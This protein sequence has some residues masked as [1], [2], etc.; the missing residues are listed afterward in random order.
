MEFKKSRVIYTIFFGFQLLAFSFLL[1]GCGDEFFDP[2]Q[3]GR[4]RP[5]PSV[6]VIL[7]SLGVAEEAKPVWEGAEEP[8]PVDVVAYE[9]DYVFSSGDVVRVSIF[10]L[11]QEGVTYTN[12]YIITETGKLSIPEVGIVESAG[13]TESQLEDEIKQIVSPSILRE[14]SVTVLLMSSQK[15]SFSI[16]GQAVPKPNRYMIPRYNFRLMDALATAGGISQF[17][18]S[19]VYIS[20]PI[21]G[22]EV[23]NDVGEIIES[24]VTEPEENTDLFIGPDG[25]MLDVITPQAGQKWLPASDQLVVAAAEF[26]CS[27]EL[28]G[29]AAELVCED[30]FTGTA[31]PEGIGL[32]EFNLI[33]EQ[34]QADTSVEQ[35][36]KN[37]VDSIDVQ[38]VPNEPQMKCELAIEP[39]PKPQQENGSIEWVFEDGKWIPVQT[40]QLDAPQ[41]PSGLDTSE[42]IGKLAE[43]VPDDFDW[44]QVGT[45]GDQTRVIEIPVDKLLGG[46]PKYNIV[47][48]PGDSIHVPVDIIGEFCIMGNVNQQGFVNLTGRPMTLK[49]AIASAGGLGALAWPKNCEVTR[50]IGKKKEETVMVDLAKIAKGEQ[51]DFFIK[52]NDL[53]NVGTH[54]TARWRAVLRNSFRATYGFGFIYDRNFG[55]RDYGTQRP[56]PNWF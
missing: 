41:L 44:D 36:L 12:D 56:I 4:F 53:I 25:E 50:R 38:E 27:N 52:P 51:P 46:D 35:M 18:V 7:D 48:R 40:G 15:R 26:V 45:G 17:N 8:K 13:L 6:N 47:I 19:Y 32:D 30:E 20:R 42:T 54:P 5:V 16:L 14:P 34:E 24:D 21:T 9:T 49:M 31:M 22:T 11:L 23:I 29:A 33:A 1:S 43:K 55:E 10:E 3:V 39:E 28:T 37:I 2:T